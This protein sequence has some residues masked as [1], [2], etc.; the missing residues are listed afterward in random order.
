MRFA[1]CPVGQLTF[2]HWDSV[3]GEQATELQFMDKREFRS[4]T[5]V[6]MVVIA[7][8]KRGL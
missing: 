5:Q 4:H 2:G 3:S 6:K 8:D 1:A 7:D